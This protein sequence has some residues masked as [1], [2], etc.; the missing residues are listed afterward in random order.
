MKTTT[1]SSIAVISDIIKCNG[2][3]YNRNKTFRIAGKVFR[4]TVQSGNS[5]G[6]VFGEILTPDGEFKQI[7]NIYDIKSSVE[8]YWKPENERTANSQVLIFEMTD[9][10]RTLFNI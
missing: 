8:V 9:Y 10:I 7:A 1:S 5:F 6:R 2:D 4:I 3:N